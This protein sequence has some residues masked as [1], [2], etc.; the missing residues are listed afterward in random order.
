MGFNTAGFAQAA[1]GMGYT[2]EE[3]QSVS[4]MFAGMPSSPQKQADDQMR[5]IQLQQ[6]QL[7]LQKTQQEMQKKT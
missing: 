1:K 3:I 2:D 5:S 7:N 6:A 4:G